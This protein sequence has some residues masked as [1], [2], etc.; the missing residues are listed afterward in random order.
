[1]A[2]LTEV[3]DLEPLFDYRRVQPHNLVF[4]DDDDTPPIPCPKRTKVGKNVGV[5][6]RE[7]EV[8]DCEEEE[9]EEEDWLPP[10][11]KVM[12][13]KQLVEDSAIKEL[14]LKKQELVSF[15]KSADDVIRAVE[16]S[17]KRKLDSSMPA[18][19]EAESEKV[20]KPAI[21]RAKIVVSIQDKGGLKQFRVY[22]DDKFERLFKMYADKVNLDQENLVFCFDGDKIGPEA[23]P[24]SLE[25]EDNDIIEVHTKKT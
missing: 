14:R 17:V 20:S 25:M 16:E 6:I 5:D 3:D 18:A 8:V 11:P 21:E 19:L 4:L 9:E 23:T 24:A 13:Q 22:A 15:A 7:L 10:P 2:D 1:M 12:V